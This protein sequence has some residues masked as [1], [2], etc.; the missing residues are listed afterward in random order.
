MFQLWI[1]KADTKECIAL[2]VQGF[3]EDTSKSI[4]NK[5]TPY[6][7]KDFSILIIER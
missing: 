7:A 6:L 3:S 4:R 1:C 2:I 5:L